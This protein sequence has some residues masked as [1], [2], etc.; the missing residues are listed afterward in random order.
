MSRFLLMA[1]ALLVSTQSVWSFEVPRLTGPVVDKAG[2]LTPATERQISAALQSLRQQGGAQIAVLTVKDL[3]GL[4][5]EDASIQ[6]TDQWKLGSESADNGVLLMVA[7]SE[8]SMRIEVG[9]GLEGN[10][11]DA[12]A[13][14]II[15]DAMVPLFRA[16]NAD[17][18][19]LVGVY[20]IA[21][22]AHPDIDVKPL[23]GSDTRNWREGHRK[24][25][26]ISGFIPILFILLLLFA[27]RRRG[28]M[29]GGMLG[30][31]LLGSM[32]GGRG[33]GFSSGGGFGGG[34]GFSGGGGGFSG[35][36]ASGSW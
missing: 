32:M 25:R 30:G 8:R 33:G 11:P 1:I 26:G 10:I 27:G 3:D 28:G 36:G 35:G 7:A 29:M 22:R 18:G 21:Q 17:Q 14:R 12:Y 5:I 13:R 19:I 6:V 20:Q 4:A 34:G 9:Q 2:L 23:F 15:D 24:K 16:G 31:M